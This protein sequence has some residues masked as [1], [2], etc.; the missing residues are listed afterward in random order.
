MADKSN[1]MLTRKIP[2]TLRQ[3]F[4]IKA[5]ENDLTMQEATIK[6]MELYIKNPKILKSK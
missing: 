5:M 2:G 3:D 4:K 1:E 6:L